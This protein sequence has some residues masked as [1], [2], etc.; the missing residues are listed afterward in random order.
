MGVKP[1]FYQWDGRHFVLPQ[2]SRP[3]IEHP[4]IDQTVDLDAIG[5]FL[6]CQ[7][8]PAPQTIYRSVRRLEAGHA[9]VLENGTS[10]L[11]LLDTRLQPQ[12]NPGMRPAPKTLHQEIRAS[13]ERMMISDVPIGGFC[14]VGWIPVSS[15]PL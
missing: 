6:E 9:L 3:L 1:L 12:K 10:E 11:V 7:F 5:T 2:N 14:Q 13:V 15:Q 8:I 4:A